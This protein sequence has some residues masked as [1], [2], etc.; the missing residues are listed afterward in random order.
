MPPDVLQNIPVHLT[1]IS[2]ILRPKSE[3]ILLNN[4]QSDCIR[5][6]HKA[7]ICE[8]PLRALPRDDNLHFILV[9]GKKARREEG[10]SRVCQT[11]EE[12][13]KKKKG[14]EA[15][16]KRLSEPTGV[17]VESRTALESRVGEVY[18]TNEGSIR[19]GLLVHERL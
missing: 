6:V 2:G 4:S 13:K 18:A 19:C 14:K 9:L 3:H 11:R 7:T 5:K 12:R 16:V 10:R 1:G 8:D 15:H 17:M